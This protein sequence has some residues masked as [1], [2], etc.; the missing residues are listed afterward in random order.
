[1]LDFEIQRSERRCSV[2]D[3]ELQPGEYF[4]SVVLDQDG[5]VVRR[6]YSLESWKGPPENCVGWWKTQVPSLATLRMK[7][8]PTDVMLHYFERLAD[9]PSKQDVRYVLSLLMLRRRIFVQRGTV[10]LEDGTE[11]ITYH[12]PRKGQEYE[13]QSVELPANR[14]EQIQSELA[15]LLYCPGTSQNSTAS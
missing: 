1:M 8:A 7:W 10:E 12:C 14:I 3:R 4:Y 11:L 13:V 9:D 15:E 5:T 6:D 2:S